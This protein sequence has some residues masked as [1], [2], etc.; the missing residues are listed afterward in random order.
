MLQAAMPY[1]QFLP[2][3]V[4]AV[5]FGALGKFCDGWKSGMELE[6]DYEAKLQFA[7]AEVMQD[8]RV[9]QLLVHAMGQ[10]VDSKVEGMVDGS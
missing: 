6:M 4:N 1:A 2:L 10:A 3:P 7:W 5:I 9:D 8:V